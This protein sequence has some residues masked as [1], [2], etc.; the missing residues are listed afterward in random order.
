[1]ALTRPDKSVAVPPGSP[2]HAVN[3]SRGHSDR[4]LDLWGK[5][6]SPSPGGYHPLAYHLIDAA[7][8]AEALWKHV[9][10]PATRDL[11]CS[12]A[13]A[14]PETVR[15]WLTF[16]AGLHDLGKATPGFQ[17]Q[18]ATQRQRLRDR[19]WVLPRGAARAHDALGLMIL[20]EM[21]RAQAPDQL[22]GTVALDLAT[23]IAAH[24]GVPGPP[25]TA[26]AAERHLGDAAWSAARRELFGVLLG[27][28]ALSGQPMP[29]GLTHPS[30]ALLSLLGGLVRVADW[31]AS[32]TSEHAPQP[33]RTDETTYTEL[34]RQRAMEA[35][36]SADWG[37]VPPP[38]ADFEELFGFPPNA[39]QRRV[40]SLAGP[41]KAPSLVLI[42]APTGSGKTEAALHLAHQW[43][44]HGHQ[45]GVYLALPTQ[46]TAAAMHERLQ[47]Y[48]GLPDSPLCRAGTPHS[49]AARMLERMG[50]GTVDQALLAVLSDQQAWVRLLGLAN[51]IVILDEVHAYDAYTSGLLGRL[52]QW[53]AALN[54]SVIML[55]ATLPEAQRSELLRAYGAM[56]APTQIAYPRVTLATG[57]YEEVAPLPSTSQRRVHLRHLAEQDSLP[58]ELLSYLDGGGCAAVVCNTV[59]G[60]QAVYCR[61][62][63]AMH[64]TD[65]ALSLL[66]GRYPQALREDRERRLLRC[67]GKGGERPAKAVVVATQVVEQSLDLDFDLL[68]TEL[69]PVD[70][71]LQ[72]LG[73]LHRHERP[74]PAALQGPQAW[75]LAPPL[76]GDGLP[77]FGASAAVYDEYVLLRTWQ[78]LQGRSG[79]MLPADT[80]PL[81]EACYAP[82]DEAELAGPLAARLDAAAHRLQARLQAQVYASLRR[83]EGSPAAGGLAVGAAG[84]GA[85]R[86]DDLPALQVVCLQQREGECCI[87]GTPLCVHLEGPDGEAPAEGVVAALLHH[88]IPIR[89]HEALQGTLLRARPESWRRLPAL[90]S[91]TPLFVDSA[92]AARLGDVR[93][94]LDAEL[95]LVTA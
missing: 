50:V 38:V 23:V 15:R 34:A 42:E 83:A 30:R 11:Y 44:R 35:A 3:G 61:L 74:R 90:Q 67:F 14:E 64:G 88:A 49:P 4:V 73:R 21:L 31:L 6:R 65:V 7:A 57:T 39:L 2:N 80:Q 79:L 43:L 13:Q 25:R 91:L 20:H 92:M 59:G 71:L 41:V 26:M 52:L 46:A 63:C 51:K 93:V 95:G 29:A 86:W 87:A 22:E 82:P 10:P 37:K 17:G 9:L 66:H 78:L 16:L 12:L 75:F 69:A 47:A 36:R 94:R 84:A 72:R 27:L 85:T 18:E 45:A 76:D 60:A 56:A 70:A 68:V 53:L 89:G 1:M 48:P 32:Q 33:P 62:R 55:S 19:G 81:V 40:A 24:H 54:C 58:R 8:A 77:D 5:L 28:S